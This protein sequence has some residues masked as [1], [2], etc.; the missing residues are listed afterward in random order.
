VT[1]SHTPYEEALA[2]GKRQD[3]IMETI[4]DRPD[5]AENWNSAELFEEIIQRWE[6]TA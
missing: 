6:Q 5:I 3:E 2:A 1:F 4:L